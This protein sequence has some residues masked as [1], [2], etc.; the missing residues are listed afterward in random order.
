MRQEVR[1]VLAVSVAGVDDDGLAADLH[2]VGVDGKYEV[3]AIRVEERR[4]QPRRRVLY[5]RLTRVRKK[6]A[7]ETASAPALS[8]G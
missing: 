7:A 1:P 5:L 6:L 4:C 8:V 3:T 2:Q